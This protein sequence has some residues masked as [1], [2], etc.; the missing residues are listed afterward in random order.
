MTINPKPLFPN[1]E[2]EN[3]KTYHIIIL[4]MIRKKKYKKLLE[5]I[6]NFK[7]Y[8]ISYDKIRNL[9]QIADDI[10][11]KEVYANSMQLADDV[12]LFW[13]RTLQ[14]APPTYYKEV[15]E[16]I[17]ILGDAFEKAFDVFGI[18]N[19]PLSKIE[20]SHKKTT[21]VKNKYTNEWLSNR[22]SALSSQQLQQVR[23]LIERRN[24]NISSNA[25]ECVFDVNII[26]EETLNELVEY[27]KNI[28][29]KDKA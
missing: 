7:S 6:G 15:S 20:P 22:M 9:S 21:T 10:K 1:G 29:V 2:L 14:A 3:S 8:N 27:L 28:D 25:L 19:F 13:N 4:D 16:L 12:R 23:L 18:T 11:S 17:Q 26:S 24:E 5:I